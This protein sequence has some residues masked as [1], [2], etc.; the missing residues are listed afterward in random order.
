MSYNAELVSNSNDWNKWIEEAISKKLINIGV[1]LWEISSGQPPFHG[2]PYD[3]G[4]ALSILQGL[5]E[6]PI[7]N[8]STDYIKIYTDCWNIEPDN[9]PT[10][11]QVVDELKVLIIKEN[12]NIKDFHLYDDHN[13]VQSSNNHQLPD[14]D[15]KISESTN[16]LYGKLSQLIQNFY[17]MNTKELESSMSSS[18]QFGDNFDIIINNLLKF[19]N[20]NDDNVVKQKTL[21]YL[22]EQNI[23]LQEINNLLLNNQNNSNSIYLLGGFN[24]LGIGISVDKQKAFEFYQKAADLGNASGMSELGRCYAYGIGTD[25]DKKKAFVLCQKAADLGNVDAIYGLGHCYTN[26][27][28]TDID[29]K[30]AFELYQKAADLG[31]SSAQYAL[32]TMY[33]NGEETVKN[34]NKAIYWYKK[35]A[36]QGV[37]YAQNKLENLKIENRK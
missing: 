34:I 21:S 31:S 2:I 35:S 18:N 12:I 24:E 32:A 17:M 37:Q 8:T 4:L 33:E 14:L 28:G 16:S 20:N 36:E 13:T 26:G 23:T 29:K 7:P 27:I 3:V 5:R 6:T 10:I 25:I 11:N 9:R 22:N 15:V 19:F 1:L 30:R